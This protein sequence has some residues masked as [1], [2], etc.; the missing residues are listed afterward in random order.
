MGKTRLTNGVRHQSPPEWPPRQPAANPDHTKVGLTRS[1]E[2]VKAWSQ[3]FSATCPHAVWPTTRLSTFRTAS[4]S[5]V[6][7]RLGL[8][9]CPEQGPH[10][11]PQLLLTHWPVLRHHAAAWTWFAASPQR[12]YLPGRPWESV[13][14]RPSAAVHSPG[15]EPGVSLVGSW[16]DT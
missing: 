2:M 13:Q 5:P 1:K 11:L 3:D 12:G 14:A 6:V 10:P 16:E 8:R 15:G 4:T 9:A 7:P